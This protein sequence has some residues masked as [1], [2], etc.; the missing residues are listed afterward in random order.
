MANECSTSQL[1]KEYLVKQMRPLSRAR[2]VEEVRRIAAQ[3]RYASVLFSSTFINIV[4]IAL[5]A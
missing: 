3:V 5:M 2:L 1:S 4:R